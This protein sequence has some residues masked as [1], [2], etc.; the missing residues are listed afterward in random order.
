MTMRDDDLYGE[1][2]AKYDKERGRRWMYPPTGDEEG[3]F[4]YDG[5]V[6]QTGAN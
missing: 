3:T 5:S 4:K 1:A 6:Q 2:K